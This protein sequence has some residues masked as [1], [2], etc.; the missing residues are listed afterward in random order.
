MKSIHIR[1]LGIGAALAIGAAVLF[2]QGPH[3]HGGPDDFGRMLNHYAD[4]LDLSSAQ[5]DQIKAVWQK[6]KPNLKPLMQQMHQNRQ[7]MSA[8]AESGAFDEG[9]AQALAALHAQTAAA[10]EVEHARIHS[11][12]FQILTA[13]QKTKF[14]QL[15]AKHRERMHNHAAPPAA[16]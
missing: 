5:Q 3:G 2:A 8:L 1:V 12:M 13:D 4:A 10:L 14:Q 16:D 15:E 6:E 7:A 9:K 11:E